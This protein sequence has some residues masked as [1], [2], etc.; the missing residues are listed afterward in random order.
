MASCGICALQRLTLI[1]A[2]SKLENTTFSS[3]ESSLQ[4]HLKPKKS[5]I[6]AERTRFYLLRQQPE[7]S[8]S[9]FILRLRPGV[10][11]CDF[12]Q[13]KSS[14]DPTEEMMFVGLAAGLLD[15][16]VQELGLDTT[17]AASG[18]LFV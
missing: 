11:Y 15:S 8:V 6:V 4:L 7:E 9:H 17:Q 10:Q 16:K 3:I 1:V 2:P 18:K 5:L 12:D 14:T 13:L